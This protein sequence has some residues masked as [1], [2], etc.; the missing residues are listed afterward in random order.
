MHAYRTMIYLTTSLTYEIASVDSEPELQP[1][2][3]LINKEVHQEILETWRTSVHLLTGDP[4]RCQRYWCKMIY[5]KPYHPP[6]LKGLV[7][8]CTEGFHH[9]R[10]LIESIKLACAFK[11]E[12]LILVHQEIGDINCPRCF[13][14]WE[15]FRSELWTADAVQEALNVLLQSSLKSLVLQIASC[16]DYTRPEVLEEWKRLYHLD[17]L[18]EQYSAGLSI[19]VGP[20]VIPTLPTPRERFW[21]HDCP[22]CSRQWPDSPE[23]A[24]LTVS[25]LGS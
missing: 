7:V 21:K 13:P 3:L 25:R 24:A 5:R 22:K 6:G 15:Y 11:A 10:R 16:E 9:A 20:L 8:R 2:L 23:C 17:N 12:S 19:V 14:R 18:P 1:K 4:L